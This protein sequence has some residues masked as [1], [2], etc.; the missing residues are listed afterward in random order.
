MDLRTR[1]DFSVKVKNLLA[2]RVG[3]RCSNPACWVLT[4]GPQIDPK[5]HLNI[6]V[7]AH[8]TAASPGGARYDP[9][10]GS[11]QR[12]SAENAIWL[13]QNCGKLVDN[14]AARYTVGLLQEWKRISEEGAR[15]A[16]ESREA[17]SAR[18]RVNDNDL[19]RF[20]AQ[21]FDRPAF[22]DRFHQEGSIE[23]FDK[24]I[25]DTLTAINTG[26][27][28]SRD[29]KPLSKAWGKTF[30]LNQK[31]RQQMDVIADLLRAI[32]SRYRDA[33]KNGSIHTNANSDGLEFYCIHDPALADWMDGT[34]AEIIKL[35]GDI[36]KEAGV[37]S[38]IFPRTIP[39]RW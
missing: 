8:I 7:A 21:C 30:L 12:Q 15:V 13:C 11:E 4:S 37:S 23:D 38:P 39:R 36:C 25:E 3:M 1:D 34:R 9:S 19:I 26:C 2:H 16:I 32:R 17:A 29:G 31:W 18:P 10:L 6:G 28:Q 22:Q 27:L 35:L 5:K 20:F 24:A 33:K 14:D